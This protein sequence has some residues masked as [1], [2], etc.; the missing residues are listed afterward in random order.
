VGSAAL[1]GAAGGEVQSLELACTSWV[2]TSGSTRRC[3]GDKEA[4][5]R[6]TLECGLNW[7]RRAPDELILLAT[8]V[9]FLD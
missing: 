7:V 5:A 4:T 2:S 6:N 9:S 1:M 3:R 8:S